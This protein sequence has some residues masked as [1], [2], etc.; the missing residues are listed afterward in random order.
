M[1]GSCVTEKT[2]II[3]P[4]EKIIPALVHHYAPVAPAGVAVETDRLTELLDRLPSL[5]AEDHVDTVTIQ[6]ERQ[7]QGSSLSKESSAIISFIDEATTEVLKQTDLDFKIESYI[8]DIAPHLAALA[9]RNDIHD[10]T[11]PNSY[12]ELIDLLIME[13]IGW[14][15]DLGILG[16]Q[17]IEKVDTAMAGFTS[18]RLSVDQCKE[19]LHAVFKKEEPFFKKLEE[20]LCDRELKVL[21]GKK[22]EFFAARLLNKEMAA[23]KLPLFVIFMLQG[24]WYEFLQAIYVEFGEK[25]KEWLNVQKITEAMVWSLQP[26][27]DESKR[28]AVIESLP[29]T[30]HSLSDKCPFDTAQAMASLADVEAEWEAI[31]GGNPSDP[32]DFELL[33]TDEGVANALQEATAEAAK[34]IRAIDLGQWFIYDDP[35]EPDEKVARIKLILNWHETEQLLLTNHNRRKVVH[36]S[37][38]EMTNHLGAGVLKKLNP[39]KSAAEGFRHHLKQVLQAVSNQN[40]K[41]KQIEETETRRAVSAEYSEQRQ[42]ELQAQLQELERKAE[43]KKQRAM[44]LRH[45]AQRKQEAAEAAVSG[46][47]QDAWVKLP[48]M[49]GTLTPCKLVAII[50]ATKTYIFANRAGLKVAEYTG[51]ELARMIVTENSEILDTGAEFESALA[52]VVTGLRED[53]EKSYEELTGDDS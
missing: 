44:V 12:F 49:E 15:E 13:C 24:P 5:T 47:R 19:E 46:L 28:K 39:Q 50:G 20:R 52:T 45:K 40:K 1:G 11:R 16:Q 42:E 4:S 32:C 6:L 35:A 17:F 33:Y 53:K 34:Q 14:S 3:A 7:G 26:E 43:L 30:I 37:Y 22:A 41:E 23:K 10:V 36:L 31:L 48:I 38:G 29:G 8:R 25:S 51:S 18:G 27:S 2:D 9:L 21:S